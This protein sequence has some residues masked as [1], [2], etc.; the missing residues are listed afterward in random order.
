MAAAGSC[1][2]WFYLLLELSSW[3]LYVSSIIRKGAKMNEYGIFSWVNL[4]ADA[5]IDNIQTLFYGHSE[6]KIVCLRFLRV[7][8]LM[9]LL[10][11]SNKYNNT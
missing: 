4:P 5:L 9:F 8:E 10:F 3:K 7:L 2:T 6:N 1:K 11:S